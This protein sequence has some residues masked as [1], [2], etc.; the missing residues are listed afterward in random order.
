MLVTVLIRV[1]VQLAVFPLPRLASERRIH[2]LNSEK[3]LIVSILR[4]RSRSRWRWSAQTKSCV[5]GSHLKSHPV[6]LRLIGCLYDWFTVSFYFFDQF[7]FQSSN[8]DAGPSFEVNQSRH[9]SFVLQRHFG[10]VWKMLPSLKPYLSFGLFV[11]FKWSFFHHH[12]IIVR[13]SWK[14]S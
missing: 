12:D 2:S 1:M 5:E 3:K 10:D 6:I 14:H 11:H 4:S 7:N 13:L 9:T 8:R